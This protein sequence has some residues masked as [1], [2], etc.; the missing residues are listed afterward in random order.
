MG[1]LKG[2]FNGTTLSHATSLRLAYKTNGFHVNQT[3]NLL[4]TVM[5][6][7]KNVLGF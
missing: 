3:Y 7:T 1:T 4:T 6:I 5:Y 2:D